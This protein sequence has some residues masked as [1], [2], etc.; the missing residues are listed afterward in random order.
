ME[1]QKICNLEI[2]LN[3]AFLSFI[4]E[5]KKLGL[6]DQTYSITPRCP[7][8][9]ACMSILKQSCFIFVSANHSQVSQNS[10]C[11]TSGRWFLGHASKLCPGQKVFLI[12]NMEFWQTLR[13]NVLWCCR[14]FTDTFFGDNLSGSFM[15]SSCLIHQFQFLF[16]SSGYIECKIYMAGRGAESIL[17]C[18]VNR[19]AY[20]LSQ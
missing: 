19:E 18:L 7:S 1:F 3:T 8:I 10:L 17:T 5:Y 11:C 13:F 14:W 20:C 4:T 2:L 12:F 16:V 9:S 6:K 15:H